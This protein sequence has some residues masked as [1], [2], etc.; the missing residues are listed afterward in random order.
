V[1]IRARTWTRLAAAA[2]VAALA[3]LAS[4]GAVA[5]PAPRC[6]TGRLQVS[7]LEVQGATSH[8]YWEMALRNTG[9]A[10]CRLQGYPGVGLLDAHGALIPDNVARQPGLPTPGVTIAHGRRAYFTF[11][12]VVSGPCAPHDFKAYGLEVYPP[13]DSARLL[14]NTH[15][16]LDICDRSVGGPPL[17]YPIRS[18][19]AL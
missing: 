7:V 11:A 15:G 4:S 1:R 18:R 3:L 19:R 5:S 2:L 8:R 10:S 9:A 6:A 16:T 12:Y 14:V 13:G 17:V